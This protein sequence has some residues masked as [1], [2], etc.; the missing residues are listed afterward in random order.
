V[1]KILH[2]IKSLGRGGAE[3][4]LV[5]SLMMH[6]LK[7][8]EFHYI[9][10]L[11]WKNQIEEQISCNGGKV[12][13]L[14]AKNNLNILLKVSDL[15]KYIRENNIDLVHCH[16]PVTGLVGR[17][18]HQKIKIPVIYTEHNLQDRYHVITRTLNKL[19]FNYQT[20]A[21]AVSEDV[22]ASIVKH[23][24][25]KIKV[26]VVENGINTTSFIRNH[27]EGL[28]IRKAYNIPENAI[29][30]GNVAVFRSQ[31]RLKEWV[32]VFAEAANLNTN[33]Y[34]MLVG[35][36]PFMEEVTA[37]ILSLRLQDKII[38]TGLQ[39]DIKPFYSAFD[40]FM[41]TSE[42]EGLPIALLEAM[43][44]ECAVI[45][46][47]AGGI[48]SLVRD[49]I[50]G[51]LVKVKEW[52]KLSSILIEFLLNPNSITQFGTNARM[53]VVDAYD[54]RKMV[55]ALEEIYERHL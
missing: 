47:N 11:P 51:C 54:I 13:C 43:S 12:T 44:M 53:R 20:E 30:V 14:D 48:K 7:Q 26:S 4:L 52:T 16:M 42:F 9:Y 22:Y 1:V 25:P 5:E 39:S 3:I 40:I 19:S 21:V 2:V 28:R 15:I 8:F 49:G 35:Q 34:G 50:D 31:K 55:T 38:L 6:N 41:M 24:H 18:I 46:T 32:L 10:F 33:V 17:Y 36:G 45:C 29:V 37:L 23:I 27:K